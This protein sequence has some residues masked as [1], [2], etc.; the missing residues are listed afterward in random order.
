M[1]KDQE[2]FLLSEHRAK[3]GAKSAK[4]ILNNLRSNEEEKTVGTAMVT[5][6]GTST[7][8]EA[9]SGWNAMVPKLPGTIKP[10]S[11][12]PGPADIGSFFRKKIGPQWWWQPTSGY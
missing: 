11:G 7:V 2:E 8:A 6:I 1:E 3:Q 12:A 4:D 9:I 5:V 10:A